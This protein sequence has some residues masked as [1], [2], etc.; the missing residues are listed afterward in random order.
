MQQKEEVDDDA[1]ATSTASAAGSSS[2]S[3]PSSIISIPLQSYETIQKRRRRQRRR[4]Q[5]ERR[6]NK[7]D[8]EDEVEERLTPLERPTFSRHDPRFL[9]LP[10]AAVAVAGLYQGYGT[11]RTVCVLLILTAFVQSLI[12][13]SRTRHSSSLSASSSSHLIFET[14]ALELRGFMVWDTPTTTTNGDC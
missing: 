9:Q 5:Q 4:R 13:R 11:V 6:P 7:E 1:T 8:V 14:L 3:S 12:M 2:S 10:A